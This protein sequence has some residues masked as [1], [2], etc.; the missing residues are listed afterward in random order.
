MWIS[1][2]ELLSDAP[3][4]NRAPICTRNHN[5]QAEEVRGD[6]AFVEKDEPGR[7]ALDKADGSSSRSGRLP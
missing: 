4:Q 1:N 3:T 7:V 5:P 6:A 2:L